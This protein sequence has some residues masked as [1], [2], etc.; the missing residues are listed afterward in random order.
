MLSAVESSDVNEWK[1]PDDVTEDVKENWDDSEEEAE[2]EAEMKG[3]EEEVE[4]SVGASP[5]GDSTPSHA[6]LA[7]GAA[8]ADEGDSD[9]SEESENSSESEDETLPA[10]ERQRARVCRR[11]E[12][13]GGATTAVSC[14]DSM[15]LY[16]FSLETQSKSRRRN[17]FGRP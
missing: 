9:V 10:P 7:Q 3:E 12:V 4:A 17:E 5:I 6:V 15:F 13:A 11:L 14:T 1:E 2:G 16:F 8:V